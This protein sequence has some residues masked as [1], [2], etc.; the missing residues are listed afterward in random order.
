MEPL[1]SDWPHTTALQQA[2]RERLRREV[3]ESVLPWWRREMTDP[4]GGHYGGRLHDG[5]LRDDLPRSGV[6]A[7]RLLW[8][9]AEAHRRHP[10]G[11]WGDSA[12]HAW[13]WLRDALW[14]TTHGGIYWHVDAQG[15][16]LA[17]HKQAYAQ[18]FAIYA[19]VAWHRAGGPHDALDRAREVFERLEAHTHAPRHGGYFEGNARDWSARPDSRLSDLE[20]E[21][22][23]SMNTLLHVLEGYTELL[24][25]WPDPRLARRVRELIE[26]FLGRVWQ[27]AWQ[28][29][30]LFFDADWR[31]HGRQVSYGHDIE[32]AWLLVRA[33]EVLGDGA[34]LSACRG[35][36]RSVAASV[37][38]HGTAEDGSLLTEG[39]WLGEPGTAGWHHAVT[40]RERVWWAQAEAMVGFWDAWQHH[41]E[42]AFA[43]AAWRA[44]CW[45]EQNLADP[46]V[47]EWRKALDADGRLLAEVPR[48]GPW[49]C[50]Y[51]HA[52]ACFE[53]MDRL[54]PP[55]AP[56]T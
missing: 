34:L 42:P 23:K 45:A 43:R 9:Y 36:G 52:R 48:A 55:D 30:G 46:S 20:P 21:A 25:A 39:V 28:A 56:R 17:D 40:R 8:T 15:R 18:G 50:P 22:A 49:E 16:P 44:W 7:A 41:R 51:H 6:L 26:L 37:L 2:W 27:P 3:F 35:L 24:R 54:Q 10:Q 32:T 19:L 47:G 5:T 1:D 11:G 14:D 33:A 38:Q 4:S 13:R 29:F 31:C 53:L 12:E